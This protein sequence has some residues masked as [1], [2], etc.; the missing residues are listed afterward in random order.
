MTLKRVEAPQKK[1]YL[2]YEHHVTAWKETIVTFL[3]AFAKL[4][5]VIIT[6][7]MSVRPSVLP[8]G[9]IRLPLT[10][11][12]DFCIWVLFEDL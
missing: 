10:D 3:G 8:H 11:F 1:V 6:F 2:M 7:V 5:E 12:H 4:R 9:A